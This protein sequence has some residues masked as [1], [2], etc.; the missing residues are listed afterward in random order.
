LFTGS[1]NQDQPV[2]LLEIPFHVHPIQVFDT[3][4]FSPGKDGVILPAI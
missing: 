4:Y 2:L 1:D 3:H